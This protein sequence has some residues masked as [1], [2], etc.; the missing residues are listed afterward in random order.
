M[1]TEIEDLK[2]RIA[3]LTRQLDESPG[4]EEI[5]E[6]EAKVEKLRQRLLEL[7]KATRP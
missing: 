6:I 1:T 5:P 4:A 3:D 7:E 2:Q